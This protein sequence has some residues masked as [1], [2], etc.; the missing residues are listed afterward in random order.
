MISNIYCFLIVLFIILRFDNVLLSLQNTVILCRSCGHDVSSSKN[1]FPKPSPKAYYYFNDTLFD[2]DEVLVEVFL[3]DL[4]FLYPVIAFYDST[5]V[6]VG[7]W[8]EDTSW[9]PGYRWKSCVCPECGAYVG[10]IFEPIYPDLVEPSKTF[11]GLILTSLISENFLN[12]LTEFPEA[13]S[14]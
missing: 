4:F 13:I 7:E 1:I 10:W 3:A 9:Y 12:S 6:G 5:C 2:K 14:N 11:Y 8:R